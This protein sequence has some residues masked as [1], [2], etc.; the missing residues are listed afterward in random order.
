MVGCDDLILE[1]REKIKSIEGDINTSKKELELFI[2]ES[3]QYKSTAKELS[4]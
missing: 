4:K 3:E 1:P 2:L